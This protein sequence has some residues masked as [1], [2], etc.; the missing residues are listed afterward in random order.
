VRVSVPREVDRRLVHSSATAFFS[1]AELEGLPDP[2]RRYLRAAIAPGTPLA[3]AARIDMR[4]QIRLGRWVPFRAEQ[5]LAP[6]DGFH[7]AARAAGVIGGFDRYVGGRG[8]MRW[9]LLGLVPVM[10]ADGPDLSRSAAGRM[11][12]EA[13]WVPTALLPRFGVT[14]SAAD[15]HHLSAR[16]R[17][18]AHQAALELVVDDQG[19]LREGVFQRWGDPDRTGSYGLHPCGGEVTAYA[20]FGGLSLPAEGRA[21]WFYGTDRWAEGEFFRYQLT[22][23]E[24]LTDAGHRVSRR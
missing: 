21:G 15:D 23:L 2:V 12:G 6:H 13:M 11:V 5:L 9:R 16:W 22:S 14:W 19:R 24:L 18:D 17:I 8:Q 3:T 20:T 7:W 10:A 4:G 1:E